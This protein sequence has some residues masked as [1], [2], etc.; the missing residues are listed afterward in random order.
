MLRDFYL[1]YKSDD[2][3]RHTCC[4]KAKTLQQAIRKVQIMSNNYDHLVL[5]YND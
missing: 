1:V 2:E 5:I 4:V 3:M